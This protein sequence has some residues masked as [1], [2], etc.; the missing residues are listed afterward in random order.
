MFSTSWATPLRMSVG[1]LAPI[2]EWPHLGVN[3]APVHVKGEER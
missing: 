2:L 3:V 1:M